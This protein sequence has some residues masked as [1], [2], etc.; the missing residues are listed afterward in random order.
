MKRKKIKTIIARK[1]N[2]FG[3]LTVAYVAT[4]GKVYVDSASEGNHSDLE[5]GKPA[6]GQ[7][8]ADGNLT[9]FWE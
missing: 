5:I 8:V 2:S 6:T 7:L 1:T 4:D 3:D 9:F